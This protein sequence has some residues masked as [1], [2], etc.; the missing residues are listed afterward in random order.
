MK[1]LVFSPPLGQQASSLHP[2]PGGGSSEVPLQSLL[3]QE[4][5]E[6]SS[7]GEEGLL[8]ASP[9]QQPD[10]QLALENKLVDFV[11]VLGDLLGHRDFAA[12]FVVDL[13]RRKAKRKNEDSPARAR[14]PIPSFSRGQSTIRWVGFMSDTRE[15]ATPAPSVHVSTRTWRSTTCGVL[16][17]TPSQLWWK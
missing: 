4:V 12:G 6:G 2:R 17:A 1:T 15:S 16:S 10:T 14:P 7:R 5:D 13:R 3:H 8:D 11:L 9:L